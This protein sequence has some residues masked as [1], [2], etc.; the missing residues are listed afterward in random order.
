MGSE[1]GGRSRDRSRGARRRRRRGSGETRTRSPSRRHR[2]RRRREA[3]EDSRSAVP[4]DVRLGHTTGVTAA[5]AWAAR[6]EIADLLES[7][8]DPKEIIRAIRAGEEEGS[9]L[10]IFSQPNQPPDRGPEDSDVPSPTADGEDSFLGPP[11]NFGPSEDGDW[12]IVTAKQRSIFDT[13]ESEKDRIPPWAK[14]AHPERPPGAPSSGSAAAASAPKRDAK[15]A[16]NSRTPPGN[17]FGTGDSKVEFPKPAKPPSKAAR[18]SYVETREQSPRKEENAEPERVKFSRPAKPPQERP[19]VTVPGEE[20]ASRANTTRHDASMADREGKD[21]DRY[22]DDAR[23]IY[24]FFKK[25]GVEMDLSEIVEPQGVIDKPRFELLTQPN[26]ASTGLGYSRMMKRF[27]RWRGTREDL[28]A[29]AGGPDAKLGILDFI[30]YL[31]QKEAAGV[32]PKRAPGFMKATLMALEAIVLD[33]R[34][35]APQRVAAGKLRLCVQASICYNDL[36]NTPLGCCEWVR[37]PGQP[38]VVGLRARSK[39]GK[40]G[41]RLWVASLRGVSPEGDG[42]LEELMTLML[43][44][45]GPRWEDH[46]HTGK[47][48]APD[49]VHFTA[50]PSRLEVDVGL[51]KQALGNLKGEGRPIGLSPLGLGALRWHG[52]K[53]TMA[54]LMQHLHLPPRVVRFQ[55]SWHSKED[56]MA[57][58]YVRESQVIILEAQEKCLSYLRKGGDLQTLIGSPLGDGP[59]P[60]G[61]KDRDGLIA[62]DERCSISPKKMDFESKWVP[63]RARLEEMLVEEEPETPV[64][65]DI[66]DPPLVVPKSADELA[67]QDALDAADFE[68]MVEALVQAKAA[69][70]ASKL[71]L[72]KM[73][74]DEEKIPVEPGP[75]CGIRGAFD[76]ILAEEAIDAESSL[77]FRC[78]PTPRGT[79]KGTVCSSVC[80]HTALSVG[81]HPVVA[82]TKSAAQFGVAESDYLIL[83]SMKISSYEGFALRVPSKEDLEDFMR[84]SIVPS[85]AYK[86]GDGRLQVFARAPAI[87]WQDFRTSEDAAALRKLWLVG[88]EICKAELERLAH[89]D[90]SNKGKVNIQA[91]LTME[92]QAVQRGMPAPG[93]DVE[94][95]SLYAL[96]RVAKAM[97]GPSASYE[98]QPWEIYINL[99]EESVLGRAGKLPKINKELVM[100]TDKKLSLKEGEEQDACPG[101]HADSLESMRNYLEIRARAFEMLDIAPYQVYKRLNE[102]YISKAV[103]RVP[104][105]MRSCCGLLDPVIESLPDQGIEAEVRGSKRKMTGEPTKQ[106]EPAK[107]SRPGYPAN[108]YDADGNPRVTC[109]VCRKKHLP[110]CPMPEGYRQ[111]KRDRQKARKKELKTTAAK[112]AAAP[113]K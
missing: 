48:P 82:F 54:A 35:N 14:P 113:K 44:A 95:P 60:Q 7:G 89:G 18:V 11:G 74:P 38:G 32:H 23:S 20:T 91:H 53:A 57:D 42:W 109:L 107:Q 17:L 5:G 102:K 80:G 93:S 68:G 103:G 29:R 62:F 55:G 1:G 94:R 10:G 71:H 6:L 27:I 76:Y 110:L 22:H 19:D 46:D 72:P 70:G 34:V 26:R 97:T 50:S 21:M 33:K 73:L 84:N 45:H 111:A 56:N 86:G 98:H 104:K 43:E 63:D 31:V 61:D 100:T 99:D 49:E 16:E 59:T 96:N 90:E 65:S 88:K 92:D 64:P 8:A 105:G 83:E 25:A 41:P 81:R 101:T 39:R 4:V 40:T 51:V 106:E 37:R 78:W 3:E 12:E 58:L 77:C 52:A 2:R 79:E 47:L 66:D 13:L 24:D 75:R 28:G 67:I 36:L 87:H 9:R 112:T 108:P 30:E 69:V 15:Q 85:A